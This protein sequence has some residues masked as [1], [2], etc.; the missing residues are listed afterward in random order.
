MR[1][2]RHVRSSIFIEQTGDAEVEQLRFAFGCDEDV[3]GLKVA[4]HDEVLMREVHRSANLAEELHARGSGERVLPRE[5]REPFATRHVFEDEERQAVVGFTAI[6]EPGDAGM[7]EA[8]EDLA[9]AAKT[10]EHFFRVGAAPEELDRDLLLEALVD[11]ARQPDGA[12][13]AASEFLDQ[14]ISAD[15]AAS[16]GAELRVLR[17]RVNAIREAL[18][19][20][21]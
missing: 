20:T 5:S 8:R 11:A 14:R 6:K 9:F 7:L 21:R 18:E 13:A 15:A 3:A 17:R 19:V 2:Q 1:D 4:V 16:V 12:H 10:T